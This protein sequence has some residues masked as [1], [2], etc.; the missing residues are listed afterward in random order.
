MYD[1]TAKSPAVGIDMSTKPDLPSP[2]QVDI[3]K[4]RSD[5]AES[6]RIM[7]DIEME[8]TP[9]GS[10]ASDI[11]KSDSPLAPVFQSTL[12]NIEKV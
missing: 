9:F 12:N 7:A 11:A 4:I 8:P 10:I 2:F 6:F 5:S 3:A 1:E